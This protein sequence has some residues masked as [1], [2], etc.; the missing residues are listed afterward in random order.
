MTSTRGSPHF[1][2]SGM[3]R[4]FA[5]RSGATLNDTGVVTGRLQILRL[6]TLRWTPFPLPADQLEAGLYHNFGRSTKESGRQNDSFCDPPPLSSKTVRGSDSV[7]EPRSVRYNSKVPVLRRAQERPF[8]RLR[9]TSPPAHIQPSPS[10]RGPG[11]GPFK[12]ETRVR[13]P[14]GTPQMLGLSR[15][16][17]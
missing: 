14:L 7:A 4:R 3:V 2:Q 15:S 16:H 13:I 12:A 9:T 5:R 6:G 10:S 11:R 8:G 17:G 1:L